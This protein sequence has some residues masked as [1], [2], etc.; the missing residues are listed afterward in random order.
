MEAVNFFAASTSSTCYMFMRMLKAAEISRP[1]LQCFGNYNI[2]LD[3]NLMCVCGEAWS[4][5]VFYFP[6]NP[7]FS[8]S[9]QVTSH[10]L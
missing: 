5:Q 10:Y 9:M 6:D 2:F 1:S 8:A 3:A 7:T 4:V